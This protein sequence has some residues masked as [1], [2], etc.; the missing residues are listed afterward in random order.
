MPKPD[1]IIFCAK[2]FCISSRALFRQCFN[3]SCWSWIS[4]SGFSFISS[5]SKAP[6]IVTDTPLSSNTSLSFLKES[7]IF[8]SSCNFLI[9][10]NMAIFNLLKIDT[11]H[12]MQ[13]ISVLGYQYFNVSAQD[14]LTYA[15]LRFSASQRI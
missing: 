3:D 8:F 13:N 1:C 9:L 12:K 14:Y 2:V 10:S 4:N 11:E 5:I 15:L 7:C 6:L